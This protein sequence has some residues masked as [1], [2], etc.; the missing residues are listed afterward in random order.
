[1]RGSVSVN[2]PREAGEHALTS[3]VG[4]THSPHPSQ[5]KNDAGVA[6]RVTSHYP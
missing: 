2:R 5:K 6:A 4:G 3:P 1:M